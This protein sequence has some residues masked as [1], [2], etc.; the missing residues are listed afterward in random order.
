[1]QINT[2]DIILRKEK[3]SK[4]IWLSERLTLQVCAG[5]SEEYLWKI[6]TLY[7]KSI[8][9][10]HRARP[11]LPDSGKAWRWARMNNTFYYA[12]ANIPDRKPCF[13]KSMLPSEDELIKLAI[14]ADKPNAAE[15]ANEFTAMA[16]QKTSPRDVQYYM[17][18]C[19]PSFTQQKAEQLALGLGFCRLITE[20]LEGNHL[21]MLKKYFFNIEPV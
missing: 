2:G 3:I 4:S 10:T 13:Y 7:K 5:T 18:N 1:M 14:E 21:F 12:Y 20:L 19:E 15:L 8:P 11:I 9:P 6:R 17:F 16:Q